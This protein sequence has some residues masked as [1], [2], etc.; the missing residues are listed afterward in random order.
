MTDIVLLT[1]NSKKEN[2][3]T[4]SEKYSALPPNIPLLITEAYLSSKDINVT[5]MDT[6][7]YPKSMKQIVQDLNDINPKVVGVVCSGS[8]PSA[9]TMS[10]VG[11]SNFF[12]ELKKSKHDFLTFVSGG[13]PTVLP[14]R[15]LHELSSDFVVLGEGYQAMEEIISF[16]RGKIEKN[17]ISSVAYFDN[18]KFGIVFSKFLVL[19]TPQFGAWPSHF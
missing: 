18:D 13:H 2:Y 12:K 7:T 6:E 15:T 17:K 4:T 3:A 16:A 10:M 1:T 5:I 14:E 9:S 19:G 11:A 8:N